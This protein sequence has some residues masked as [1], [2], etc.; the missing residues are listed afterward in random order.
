MFSVQFKLQLIFLFS[1][2]IHPPGDQEIFSWWGTTLFFN[3]PGDQEILMVSLFPGVLRF[4]STELLAKIFP[5]WFKSKLSFQDLQ[6]LSLLC[7]WCQQTWAQQFSVSFKVQPISQ[8]FQ[9]LILVCACFQ[10]TQSLVLCLVQIKV[11]F[12][13][14]P[15]FVHVVQ[16]LLADMANS[17]WSHSN[18]SPFSN[19]HKFSLIV[20]ML[21]A[22]MASISQS[23]SNQSP[24]FKLSKD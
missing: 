3:P 6:H 10:Q 17:S 13:N 8:A 12:S 22:D 21:L 24:F 11:H 16:V 9:R 5:V 1:W 2:W 19:F 18:H 7:A 23:L 15:K 4:P 20:Y 14:F